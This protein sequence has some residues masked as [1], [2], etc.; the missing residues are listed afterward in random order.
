MLRN[1]LNR[2][3]GAIKL[4][5]HKKFSDYDDSGDDSNDKKHAHTYISFHL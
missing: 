2:I 4:V 5:R 3:C 1:T